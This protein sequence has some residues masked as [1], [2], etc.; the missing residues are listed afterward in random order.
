MSRNH[1]PVYIDIEK[2]SRDANIYYERAGNGEKIIVT[3]DGQ[4]KYKVYTGSEAATGV[5]NEMPRPHLTTEDYE[6]LIDL[7]DPLDIT[8]I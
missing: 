3:I 2:F 1:I 4:P 6:K 8:E 5:L 7:L